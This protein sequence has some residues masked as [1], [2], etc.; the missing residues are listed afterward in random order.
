MVAVFMIIVYTE[1]SAEQLVSMKLSAVA[2]ATETASAPP[3][4]GY[5]VVSLLRRS[6]V[7]G[8]AF[9]AT[10]NRDFCEISVSI[11]SPNRLRF[12]R[13]LEERSSSVLSFTPPSFT[14]ALLTKPFATAAQTGGNLPGGF[15][16]RAPISSVSRTVCA[17]VLVVKAL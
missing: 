8:T 5:A 15:C 9:R 6:T 17:D 12:S 7:R 14:R 16:Q 10:R 11:P 2:D 4:R 3:A 13:T 1:D